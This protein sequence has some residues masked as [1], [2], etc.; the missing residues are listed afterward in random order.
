MDEV[1]Y[2]VDGE[3]ITQHGKVPDH[4]L[5][6]NLIGCKN[7]GHQGLCSDGGLELKGG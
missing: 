3:G 7:R 1:W 6:V 2:R 4:H 5:A